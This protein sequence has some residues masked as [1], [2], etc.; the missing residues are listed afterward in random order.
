M[1]GGGEGAVGGGV[2]SWLKSTMLYFI[3]DISRLTFCGK[4]MLKYVSIW[5]WE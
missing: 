3:Y 5:Q 4:R 1:A 2:E